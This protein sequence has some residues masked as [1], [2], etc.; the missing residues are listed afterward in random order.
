MKHSDFCVVIYYHLTEQWS[1]NIHSNTFSSNCRLRLEQQKPKHA[2]TAM[3]KL[4]SYCTDMQLTYKLA[5]ELGMTDLVQDL[6]KGD[7]A[8]YLKD[9]VAAQY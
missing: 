1:I 2:M 9:T 8:P 5:S 7:A 3:K 4:L 6:L